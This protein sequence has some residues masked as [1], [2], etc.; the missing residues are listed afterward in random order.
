MPKTKFSRRGIVFNRVV[1]KTLDSITG[2]NVINNFGHWQQGLKA[3]K[4][5]KQLFYGLG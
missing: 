4:K 5:E 2:R 1:V 3:Y